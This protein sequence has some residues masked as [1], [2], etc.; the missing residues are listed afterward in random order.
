MCACSI[1]TA[2]PKA[3]AEQASLSQGLIPK[4]EEH[5]LA[6]VRTRRHQRSTTQSLSV[7]TMYFCRL[8]GLPE[9]F[10]KAG[11]AFANL[12]PGAGGGMPGLGGIPGM[13]PGLGSTG[14]IGGMPQMPNPEDDKMSGFGGSA[15]T[16]LE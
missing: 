1:W 7:L 10:S 11:E 12:T 3:S 5:T 8:L 15:A 2:C 14:G 13:P 16:D 9:D 6:R 4:Q